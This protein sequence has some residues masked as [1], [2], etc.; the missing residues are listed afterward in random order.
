MHFSYLGPS[1]SLRPTSLL[2]T[3]ILTQVPQKFKF[4]VFDNTFYEE[5]PTLSLK[6]NLL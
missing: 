2:G 1:T 4:V 3:S 5:D 6:L